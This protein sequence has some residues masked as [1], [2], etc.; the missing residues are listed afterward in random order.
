M[1]EETARAGRRW[2]SRLQPDILDVVTEL[3]RVKDARGGDLPILDLAGIEW[4]I[5][6]WREKGIPHPGIAEPQNGTGL[7]QPAQWDS[8]RLPFIR[9]PEGS[10]I[11]ISV[12]RQESELQRFG[13]PI[14]SSR[15]DDNVREPD[16][17]STRL[18]S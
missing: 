13:L 15:S 9:K 1:T 7:L 6:R 12:G 11:G 5:H 14:Q 17:K 8:N 3:A 10:G 18:N 16:R 4:D 2:L